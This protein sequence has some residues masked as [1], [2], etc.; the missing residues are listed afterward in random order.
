MMRLFGLV[1]LFVSVCVAVLSGGC[2][3]KSSEHGSQS[4]DTIVVQVSQLVRQKDRNY[5]VYT[6]RTQAVESVEIRAR[7]TGY[8]DKI[9][10]EAGALVK[11][12]KKLFE[13][14]S[15]T[16]QADFDKAEA[17]V[18]RNEAELKRLSSEL[19]RARRLVVGSNISREDYEKIQG[20]QQATEAAKEEAKAA[21]RSAKQNLDFCTVTAP[22]TGKISRNFITEGNLVNANQT[23]LA[24]INSVDR[25]YAY[26]DVDEPTVLRLRRMRNKRNNGEDLL[27]KP[28]PGELPIRLALQD[29]KGFPHKG[30]IESWENRL[31]P[32]TGT[33]NVRGVFA[34]TDGLLDAGQ[35]VRIQLPISE[36]YEAYL[37][38]ERALGSDQGQRFLYVVNDKNEI[39]YRKVTLG[40]SRDGMVPVLSGVKPGEWVVVK[41]IQRLRPGLKVQKKEVPMPFPEGWQPDKPD[42]K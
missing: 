33:L 19:A 9:D 21:A 1:G 42:A 30:Y 27:Y 20:N 25:F 37:V 18:K 38:N 4:T 7:V 40:P 5:E 41:G 29:E 32:T 14:D 16:F 23:L 8:L 12:D 15:R 17:A 36:S 28:K 39:E 11:K 31:D 10:F 6:G 26:F 22:V 3:P 24:R 35:F 2:G 13:I 34:N